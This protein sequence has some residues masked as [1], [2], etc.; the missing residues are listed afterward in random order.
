[1]LTITVST[2]KQ[3]PVNVLTLKRMGPVSAKLRNLK[4]SAYR[5]V[6]GT[7][8]WGVAWIQDSKGKRSMRLCGKCTNK[9]NQALKQ[10]E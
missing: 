6:I 10:G 9:A 2:T 5:K 8:Q 7:K 4:C 1:M 3:V